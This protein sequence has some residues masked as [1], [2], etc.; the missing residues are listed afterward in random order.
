MFEA[1]DSSGVAKGGQAWAYAQA[2]LSSAQGTLV[3]TNSNYS[4]LN[5]VC[6]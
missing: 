6:P 3:M 4:S 5:I 1:Y 2:T